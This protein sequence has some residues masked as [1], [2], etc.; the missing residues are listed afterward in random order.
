MRFS[1]I[2]L[3]EM[4]PELFTYEFVPQMEHQ[5][6]TALRHQPLVRILNMIQ[7]C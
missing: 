5:G 4:N 7:K 6:S 3:E 2:E 1:K